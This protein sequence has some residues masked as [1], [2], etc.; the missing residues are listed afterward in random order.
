MSGL[1]GV[2]LSRVL[3]DSPELIEGL[4]S[5]PDN[6][7]RQLENIARLGVGQSSLAMQEQDLKLRR[8][9]SDIE[10]DTRASRVRTAEIARLIKEDIVAEITIIYLGKLIFRIKSPLPTID[11][12]PRPVASAKK[13]QSTIPNSKYTGKCSMSRPRFKNLSKTI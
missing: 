1:I 13:F 5:G 7:R 9:R 11:C 2:E 3:G 6:E 4:A 12:K 10:G 8:N